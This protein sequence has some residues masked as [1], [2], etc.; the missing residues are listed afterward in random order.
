MSV[1]QINDISSGSLENYKSLKGTGRYTAG[2]IF[3][4]GVEA[5]LISEGKKEEVV[6]VI[7]QST[8]DQ[9]NG[10]KQALVDEVAS[11]KEQLAGVESGG[12]TDNSEVLLNAEKEISELKEEIQK[13]RGFVGS[14]GDSDEKAILNQLADGGMTLAAFKKEFA[15]KYKTAV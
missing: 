10:E 3:D 9:L 13:L 4:L 6:N 12:D 7:G 8:L 11:L 2:K 5:A 15:E 1:L 14:S